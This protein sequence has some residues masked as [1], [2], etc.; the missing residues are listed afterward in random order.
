M[1]IINLGG[2][3]NSYLIP[4]NDKYLLIDTGYENGY[5]SFINKLKTKDIAPCDIAYIF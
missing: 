3:T 2:I 4:L 5:G 1:E